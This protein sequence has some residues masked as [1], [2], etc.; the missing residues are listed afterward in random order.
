MMNRTIVWTCMGLGA[1]IVTSA[2]AAP[3][4]VLDGLR[5]WLDASDAGTMFTDAGKTTT[6]SSDGDLVAVW[7]DKSGNGNDAVQLTGAIAQNRPHYRTGVQN[8]RSAVS[9]ETKDLVGDGYVDFLDVDGRGDVGQGY[10]SW[11]EDPVDVRPFHIF[12]VLIADNIAGGSEAGQSKR[13]LHGFRAGADRL[14][15]VINE[16]GEDKLFA[17]L[18]GNS[19]SA[20]AGDV[21]TTSTG[22]VENFGSYTPNILERVLRDGID[23][24]TGTSAPGAPNAIG[25][26]LRIGADKTGYNPNGNFLGD[27]MELAIYNTVLSARERH[28][29]GTYLEDK[30]GLDT[31]Y[32]PEPSTF[33]LLVL[34]LAGLALAYGRRRRE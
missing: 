20:P 6:V 25:D 30:W 22:I 13:I 26:A 12:A 17:S 7:A 29:I 5:I 8:G 24:G 33:A 10:D 28:L 1:L 19:V 2:Q 16:S 11:D 32:V 18:S 34:G 15:W 31:A 21:F 4:P 9:F 23:V 14:Q 3:I 27:V